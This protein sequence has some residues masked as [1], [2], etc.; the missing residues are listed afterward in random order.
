MSAH[1][2][3]VLLKDRYAPSKK[4]RKAKYLRRYCHLQKPLSNKVIEVWLDE[5]LAMYYNE[6]AISLPDVSGESATVNFIK[7]IRAST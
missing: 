7:A 1:A 4:S 3:L 2:M 6:Y 5:W